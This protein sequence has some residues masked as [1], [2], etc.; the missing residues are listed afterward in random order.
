MKQYS[1]GTFLVDDANRA[2]FEACRNVADLQDVDPMP[3]VLVADK[4]CGKTHLLYSIV[5]RVRATSADTG[6]AYITADNFHPRVRALVSDPAP[7][8]QAATAILM[9]DQLDAFA[10]CLDEL[11]AVVRVFLHYGHPVIVAS[12]TQPERL[13]HLPAGLRDVM[14]GGQTIEIA[15]P[16]AAARAEIIHRQVCE[17]LEARIRQQEEELAVLRAAAPA[18]PEGDAELTALRAELDASKAHSDAVQHELEHLRAELALQTASDKEARYLRGRLEAAEHEVERLR[19][20]LAHHAE[21]P[22][23]TDERD[24]ELAALR[25]QLSMAQNAAEAAKTELEALRHEADDA[26]AEA[27]ELWAELERMQTVAP[28]PEVEA[29]RQQAAEELAALREEAAALRVRLAEAEAAAAAPDPQVDILRTQLDQ[30]RREEAQASREAGE[31]LRRVTALLTDVEANSVDLADLPE[32]LRAGFEQVEALIRQGVRGGNHEE[33]EAA[34]AM[35][36][37]A[38][39]RLEA[40]R[41]QF[42]DERRTLKQSYNEAL[43][44]LESRLLDAGDARKALEIERDEARRDAAAVRTAHEALQAETQRL[45]QQLKANRDKIETTQR[46]A[47]TMAAAAEEESRAAEH[48][49]AALQAD[50][51]FTRDSGRNVGAELAALQRR[52]TEAASVAADLG[53]RL[54]ISMQGPVE[55]S[56][57]V[58]AALSGETKDAEAAFF[59]DAA[60]EDDFPPFPAGFAVAGDDGFG[61]DDE[62]CIDLERFGVTPNEQDRLSQPFTPLNPRDLE[63]PAAGKPRKTGRHPFRGESEAI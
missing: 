15:Y 2:A 59:G 58:A 6:L 19:A 28:D 35:A 31:M 36:N 29:A 52:L 18:P 55:V 13:E 26:R 39:G 37:D 51:D 12:R 38:L 22:A 48:R 62:D 27:E 10:D 60:K 61:G 30:A 57:P 43:A 3:V 1:F 25:A 42:D 46:E 40:L 53:R 47:E 14:R 63:V 32:D 45:S 50:L 49:V 21:P 24:A 56:R 16:D 54:T 17:E 4:G 5:N 33:L 20:D 7:L 44:N 34:R 8:Q 23:D 11:E 9:V 41:R